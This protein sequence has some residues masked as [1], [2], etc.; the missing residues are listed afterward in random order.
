MQNSMKQQQVMGNTSSSALIVSP[1]VSNQ[2]QKQ[3]QATQQYQ[4]QSLTRTNS[5]TNLIYQAM[6][7]ASMNSY[8]APSTPQQQSKALFLENISLSGLYCG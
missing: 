4:H 2:Q 5:S 6:S 7:N 8:T 1:S 3:Q